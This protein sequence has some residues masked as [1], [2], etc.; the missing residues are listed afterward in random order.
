MDEPS[1]LICP[2][3]PAT[4]AGGLD[5]CD[6]HILCSWT[7]HVRARK[8]KEA[9]RTS[10]LIKLKKRHDCGGVVLGSAGSQP[11]SSKPLG[12]AREQ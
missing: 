4:Y 2:A 6:V 3:T 5:A 9:E 1:K 8:R 7:S 10:R 12:G 11:R